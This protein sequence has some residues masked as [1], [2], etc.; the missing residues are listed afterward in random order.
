MTLLVLEVLSSLILI[1]FPRLRVLVSAKH[2]PEGLLQVQLK[3]ERPCAVRLLN[4]FGRD[5]VPVCINGKE[6]VLQAEEG[7]LI[8]SLP[9][10]GTALLT[11]N[12]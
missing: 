11:A 1:H 12:K 8:V 9:E 10:A 6:E 7:I 4:T 2:G 3:S 5:A